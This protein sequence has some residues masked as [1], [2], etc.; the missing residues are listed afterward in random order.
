MAGRRGGAQARRRPGPSG[1]GPA[2]VLAV[3]GRPGPAGPPGPAGQ[4]LLAPGP[5]TPDWLARPA[6]RA[7]RGRASPARPASAT[8]R[9]PGASGLARRGRRRGGKARC[10]LFG[11]ERRP[12]AAALRAG[13]SAARQTRT[14][15]PTAVAVVSTRRTHSTGTSSHEARKPTPRRIIRSARSMRPPLAA[16][17]QGL[18]LGPL[19]GDERADPDDGQGQEDQVPLVDRHQVPRDAAHHHDVGHPV[20]HRVEEGP[21]DRRR[22]RRLGHRAVEQVV[23]AGDGQERHGQ[24]EM[25]GGDGHRGTDGE[26]EPRGGQHVGGDA[27]AHEGLADRTGRPVHPLAPSA[28]EHARSLSRPDVSRAD[29]SGPRL[30]GPPCR[31][32]G[33]NRTGPEA[34]GARG[35]R[36]G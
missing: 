21:P 10:T 23:E 18:G 35:P 8:P 33:E 30:L 28:V 29:V 19:V 14:K 13:P 6:H 16:E 22:S 9:V 2:A 20:G 11:P 3:A 12:H 15:R 32:D 4:R 24:Q 7:A 1:P 27:M 25:P 36:E 31:P 26:H 34:L 5:P 17:S